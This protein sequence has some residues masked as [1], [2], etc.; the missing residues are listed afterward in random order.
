MVKQTMF[1]KPKFRKY[2]DIVSLESTSSARKSIRLLNKEF[3]DADTRAK[4]V[5][6]KRVTL[7]ASNRAYAMAQ[8]RKLSFRER[9]ELLHIA[10]MYYNASLKMIIP[11]RD[12][13]K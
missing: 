11:S 2:S 12:A 7:L 4:K 6:V 9:R 3:R 8:K 10:D 5:R 13:R 1:G